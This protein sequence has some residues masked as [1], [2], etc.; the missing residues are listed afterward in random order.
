MR[1][2]IKRNPPLNPH[3]HPRVIWLSLGRKPRTNR[4]AERF[5]KLTAASFFVM[6][7]GIVVFLI[8]MIY[9]LIIGKP[10]GG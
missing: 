2:W 4:L 6:L 7:S 1:K 3:C 10:L 8:S 9:Y 5:G